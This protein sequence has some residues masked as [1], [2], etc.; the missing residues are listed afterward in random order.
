VNGQSLVLAT[1]MI[2]F[3]LRGNATAQ[4][5]FQKW[6]RPSEV[7]VS[8]GRNQV[9][10]PPGRGGV[11]YFP[12]EV[13]CVL[14]NDPLTFTMVC[15]DTTYLWSGTSFATAVPIRKVLSPGKAGSPDNNYA[16]IGGIFHDQKRKRYISFYHAE[17]KEG[18]GKV[19]VNGVQG[20]YGTVC[21]GEISETGNIF[22]KRGPCITADKRKLPRGWETEGGPPE[23]WTAQGL[24]EP[25][26]CIDAA[27][28]Y[29]LC[30]YAEWSN[31]LK[32]GVQICVAR[33]PIDKVGLPGSWT[34][35]YRG[36]FSEPGLGGHDTPV[37]SA[38]M[39]ADTYTPHVQFIKQWNR[40]VMVFGMGVQS[41][42]HSRPLK[43]IQGGLY[44]A[45]SKDG[46]IWTKPAQAERVFAFVIN[47]Q[48]CK[49]HPTLVV[50]R[51]S[52]NTLTG[53]LLYGYTPKWPGTPHHL[54]G[55]TITI[56]LNSGRTTTATTT[57]PRTKPLSL[58]SLRRMAKSVKV[59]RNGAPIA[60]DLS[61]VSLTEEQLSQVAT[62]ST[63]RRLTL[64]KTKLTDEG[65]QKLTPLTNLTGLGMWQT[66]ITS[67]GLR[68]VGRFTNLSY[69]SV[70]GNRR[71]TDDGLKHLSKLRKLSWI[72][73]SYT[74]VT[75]GGMQHL[76]K[77][78]SLSRLELANTK[79]TD[80]G[81]NELM[82]IKS[83][84]ILNVTGTKVSPA[85]VAKFKR[86]MPNCKVT[87]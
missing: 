23:A 37:I 61:D 33:S 32:R 28:K 30:Y 54:G 15:G 21:V 58:D 60:V 13:I 77:L 38:G 79:L 20:F 85:G 26:V 43:A 69:L 47:T 36:R 52:D 63:L 48:E 22:K 2:L 11:S 7:A 29:L 31:R 1:S 65:L 18:I 73:L 57:S 45:T 68:H 81:L 84:K 9:I 51:V 56:S 40:Y 24:G 70:E 34:K 67:D 5:V 83:L 16:G 82:R 27:G 42:I 71:I 59:N 64:P 50:S 55:C 75:D 35:Y 3:L 86:A 66:R 49:I 14:K 80:R 87:R 17:D 41:E 76:A 39:K 25:S 10:I 62:L 4:D 74:G 44:V 46:V 12:D 72:G 6:P 19:Q 8:T 53:Q 78:P